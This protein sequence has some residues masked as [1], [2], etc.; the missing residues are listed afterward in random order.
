YFSSQQQ[1]K[2]RQ[3]KAKLEMAKFLQETVEELGNSTNKLATKSPEDFKQFMSKVR[4]GAPVS[5]AEILWFARAFQDQFTLEN[6][7]PPQLTAMC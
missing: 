7:T 3:L 4:A 6:L 2:E 1:A 5:N